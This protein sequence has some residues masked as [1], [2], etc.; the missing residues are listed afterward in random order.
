MYTLYTLHVQLPGSPQ[1]R[2]KNNLKI[3]SRNLGKTLADR[4]LDRQLAPWD[5]YR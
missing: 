3:E 5:F 1:K 2:E 4:G